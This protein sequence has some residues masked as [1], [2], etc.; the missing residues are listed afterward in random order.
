MTQTN[1]AV[2]APGQA[3]FCSS[4]GGALPVAT[5]R[6]PRCGA[7]I[8]AQGKAKRS[9]SAMVVAV[10]AVALLGAVPCLGI[11]AAIA[12]PNFLRYQ[13]RAKEAGARAELQELVLAEKEA[14][15]NGGKYV[16]LGPLPSGTPG[17]QKLP[18]SAADLQFASGLGWRP[19]AATHGQF[20]VAVAEDGSGR[21]AASFCMETDLDGDGSRAVHVAFLPV[22]GSAPPAPCTTP[23]PYDPQRVEA[24]PIKMSEANVY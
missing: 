14:A 8:T 12:I 18:L 22:E 19:A 20:R 17:A 15:L 13:L 2:G 1:M 24:M 4:C 9:H 7:V 16:A 21:Q 6:C 3:R 23:V 5:A 10:V 11:L